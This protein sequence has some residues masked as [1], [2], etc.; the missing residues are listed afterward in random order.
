MFLTNPLVFN[1]ILRYVKS[2]SEQQL[3]NINYEN[4]T[5]TC[6]PEDTVNGTTIV[7]CGLV[8]WSMFNDTFS[9]STKNNEKLP[10]TKKGI[11]WKSDRD[12]KYGKDVFPKNFQSGSLIG[13]AHL[14]ESIPVSFLIINNEVGF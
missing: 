7:P 14:N 1:N 2:R 11:S 10:I 5:S 8:A 4:D 12:H 6:K 3:R 13:G 9:F